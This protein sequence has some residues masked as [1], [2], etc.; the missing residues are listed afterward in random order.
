MNE[1]NSAG[2][3]IDD[4]LSDI[5]SALEAFDNNPSFDT[6]DAFNKV[7]SKVQ[8]YLEDQLYDSCNTDEGYPVDD[9]DSQYENQ[10][11]SD[12]Y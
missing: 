4:I 6:F 1:M 8:Y 5:R 10:F 7:T 3:P 9:T 2:L 12:T 11:D